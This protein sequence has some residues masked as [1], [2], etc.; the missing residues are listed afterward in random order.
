MHFIR[1]HIVHRTRMYINIHVY[2]FSEG[3]RMITKS[4]IF[5]YSRIRDVFTLL[6]FTSIELRGDDFVLSSS[7]ISLTCC[8]TTSCDLAFL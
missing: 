4:I 1:L 5:L 8:I 6:V 7:T 3:L 2:E